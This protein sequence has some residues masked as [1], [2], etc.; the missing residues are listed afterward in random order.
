MLMNS[1]MG[2]RLR[3][4][5]MAPAFGLSLMIA[6]NT[7]LGVSFEVNANGAAFVHLTTC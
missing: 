7:S 6:T 2:N 1:E 4:F 3:S 5:E